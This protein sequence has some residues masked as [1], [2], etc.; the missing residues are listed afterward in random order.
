[1]GENDY[2]LFFFLELWGLLETGNTHTELDLNQ[3]PA[4]MASNGIAGKNQRLTEHKE[5]CEE[6]R[7]FESCVLETG[8]HRGKQLHADCG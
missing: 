6:G 2:A 4:Q 7:Y 1:M 3:G 8:P 5:P